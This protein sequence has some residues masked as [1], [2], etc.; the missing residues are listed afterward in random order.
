[1]VRP[2]PEDAAILGATSEDDGEPCVLGRPPIGPKV[3]TRITVEQLAQVERLA[4]D[5]GWTRAEA[6]RYVI[7]WGFA[8][9]LRAPQDRELWHARDSAGNTA[10]ALD[11]MFRGPT[12]PPPKR[13]ADDEF[14]LRSEIEAQAEAQGL[15]PAELLGSA[16]A[17]VARRGGK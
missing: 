5:A 8:V 3:S 9:I 16:W 7:G 14:D 1:M 11:D 15:S 10:T 17:G 12:R 4:A 6:L 13:Q 2:D